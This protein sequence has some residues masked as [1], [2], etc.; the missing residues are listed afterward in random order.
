MRTLDFAK[1]ST[2]IHTDPDF[3]EWPEFGPDPE[4]DLDRPARPLIR[5]LWFDLLTFPHQTYEGFASL[6]IRHFAHLTG[7]PSEFVETGLLWFESQGMVRTELTDL[8]GE[9]SDEAE[10]RISDCLDLES[11]GVGKGVGDRVGKGVGIP[12]IAGIGP[13]SKFLIWVR[14]ALKVRVGVESTPGGARL[15]LGPNNAKGHL[16]N[17]ARFADSV[18]FREFV[19]YYERLGV[20]WPDGDLDEV[21]SKGVT[22]PVG[23]GVGKGVGNGVGNPVGKGEG[24]NKNKNKKG[25]I[26]DLPR[27]KGADGNPPQSLGGSDSDSGDSDGDEEGGETEDEPRWK[28]KG[29]EFGLRELRIAKSLQNLVAERNSG[30]SRWDDL[31]KYHKGRLAND[32]RLL[33]EYGSTDRTVQ[34]PGED[35]DQRC[36]VLRDIVDR[37]LPDD[38]NPGAGANKFPGW[39]GVV[40]ALAPLRDSEK[41]GNLLSSYRDW[42]KSQ[43]RRTSE[44]EGETDYARPGGEGDELDFGRE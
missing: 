3:Y 44:Y 22:D 17:L 34:L 25:Q 30:Y 8:K 6:S 1:L 28:R 16:K 2:T 27:N 24:A 43:S 9:L 35:Y 19:E 12:L 20:E 4:L 13:A 7:W 11:N 40:Q 37:F 31:S 23:N 36:N 29:F 38:Y 21:L 18:L 10:A 42:R 5:A 15:K 39:G 33:I 14:N 26:E 41:L 32:A